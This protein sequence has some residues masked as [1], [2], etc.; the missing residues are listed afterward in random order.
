ML[1]GSLTHAAGN[2]GRLADCHGCLA[3]ILIGA[4]DRNRL[5][6]R[7][8]RYDALRADLD[9]GLAG[10][11]VISSDN[12]DTVNDMD[13]V[14]LAGI[15]TV[16]EADAGEL[17]GFAAAEQCF[18]G[19]AAVYA[20]V[21]VQRLCVLFR[22]VA[23]NERNHLLL[24]FGGS[25]ENLRKLFSYRGAADNALAA[26]NVFI[27]RHSVRIIVTAGKAAPAAV[28]SGK[29]RAKVNEQL[30]FLDRENLRCVG[31]QNSRDKTDN[32]QKNDRNNNCTHP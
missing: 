26:G 23:G 14:E 32:R 12:R 19:F 7:L 2:A 20:F 11:A 27:V 9:A 21:L 4:L 22:A 5:L 25:A 16:A 24:R 8:Q 30:I 28:R 1:A 29:L 31:K 18:G 15:D 17:A 13:R 6:V 10:R 3:G